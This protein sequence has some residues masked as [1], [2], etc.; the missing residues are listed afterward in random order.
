MYLLIQR[1]LQM[2]TQR[3]NCWILGLGKGELAQMAQHSLCMWRVA[4]SRPAFSSFGLPRWLSGKESDCQVG[5]VG[6]TPG[7]GRPSREG[8]GNP[9]QYFCLGNPMDREAWWA[10]VHGVT[11]IVTQLND[12]VTITVI[13][14]WVYWGTSIPFSI[15]AT[16]IHNPTDN[17]LGFPFL[18]IQA[19]TGNL[20]TFWR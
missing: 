3:W 5:N 10:T 4:G 8:K 2:Y 14:F 18:H 7:L 9:L 19:S 20:Y 13:L 11:K 12:W 6:L 16:Q 15:A 1:F 17:V